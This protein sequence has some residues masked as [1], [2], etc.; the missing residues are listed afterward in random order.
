MQLND[1]NE[2]NKNDDD[3]DDEIKRLYANCRYESYLCKR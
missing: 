2:E 3:D 1:I